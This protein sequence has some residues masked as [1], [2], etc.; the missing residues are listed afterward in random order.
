MPKQESP[1]PRNYYEEAVRYALEVIDG[2]RPACKWIKLQAQRFIDD[3]V[4]SQDESFPYYLD[5][6][7]A[8]HAAEFLELLPLTKWKPTK[9]IK[10]IKE[11]RPCLVLEPWQCFAVVNIFGW[12]HRDSGWRRYR[13]VLLF[14]PRKNG[15]SEFAAAIALY[16]MLADGEDAAEVYCG[17]RS[18]DQAKF[19]FNAAKNMI[20]FRSE[21]RDH[22]GIEVLTERIAVP[23]TNSFIEKLIGDPP[24]GSDPQLY[25]CDEF[26]EHRTAAQFDTM[27]TG[28]I[29][30]KQSLIL[31]TTTAGINIEGPC[32]AYVKDAEKALMG[33]LD[34]PEL[35]AMI[36]TV[37]ADVDYGSERALQQANPAYDTLIDAKE[38]RTRQRNAKNSPRNWSKFLIK[39]LNVWQGSEEAYFD[40]LAWTQKCGQ[41]DSDFRTAR[42]YADALFE[43]MRGRRC[44]IG[45]D[46]SGKLDMTALAL[47]FP[48]DNGGFTVIPRFYLPE[49]TLSSHYDQDSDIWKWAELGWIEKTEG[50]MIDIFRV[51]DD[52]EA[53]AKIFEIVELPYD[54]AHSIAFIQALQGKGTSVNLVEW[55]NQAK[56]TSD[57]MKECAGLIR[58]GKVRHDGNPVMKW[59]ISNVIR[60]KSTRFDLDYPSK[61]TGENKIDGPVAMIQAVGRSIFAPE[62]SLPQF[63]RIA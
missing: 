19:I 14:V 41:P 38:L 35:F 60:K 6:D 46:L 4:A 36:F 39:H 10:G 22:F 2:E 12:K 32:Y 23:S 24:D 1:E 16:M 9:K 50:N 48:E 47:V 21:I 18:E 51:A 43:S 45:G 26:H 52:V 13:E 56:Y 53:F 11:Q 37:D 63:S 27:S 8:H 5:V 54:P 3:L 42:E 55:P 59:Q 49:D 25:C 58:S 31:I 28:M 34:R 20:R 62:P 33:A 57:P 15:K 40:T 61:S 17:G 44:F 7:A 29:S 30:R